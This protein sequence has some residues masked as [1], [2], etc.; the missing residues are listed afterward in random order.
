[1]VKDNSP[2]PNQDSNSK[3]SF[4]RAVVPYLVGFTTFVSIA[5]TK[6]FP[7]EWNLFSRLRGDEFYHGFLKG[8]GSLRTWVAG[9][10]GA[11]TAAITAY[12][13]TRRNS[14]SEQTD[15]ADLKLNSKDTDIQIGDETNRSA[16]SHKEKI[17]T[18]RSFEINR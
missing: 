2:K 14:A 17:A 16:F 11:L 15:K 8:V 1:M 9:L 7:S 18:S 5:A 10:A 13:C 4:F 3:R 6:I 12:F